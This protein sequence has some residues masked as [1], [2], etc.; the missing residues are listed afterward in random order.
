MTE[1]LKIA[2]ENLYTTFS[3]Y[4]FRST[5]EGCPCCVSD[6]DKEKF[7]SKQLRDLVEDDL[8]RYAFKAIT[9]WGDTNDFKHYLPRIFELLATTDFVVDTF[10]VLGKLEYGKWQEWAE[11]EKTS[12]TQFLL[13]WWTDVVKRK[14]YF[15]K[16][17]FTEIYK[18]TNNIEQ[19]LNRWTIS[20]SDNS[21]SN[22]VDLVLNYYNDLKNKKKEFRDFDDDSVGNLK[23]W[24][25]E[26]SQCLEKGFF[27][28]ADID[29]DFADK[30]SIAQYIYERA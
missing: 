21:F 19:L 25:K 3:I 23:L 12:I 18:L 15:D 14:K 2:I 26:K 29:R 10:V 4:P 24:I 17:V 13:A 28:F 8:S 16:E 9:T 22:F 7:H 11:T 27:H 5:I 1:E 20:F 30:I 6:S